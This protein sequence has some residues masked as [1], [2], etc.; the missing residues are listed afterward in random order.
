MES[1][2]CENLVDSAGNPLARVL[3]AAEIIQQTSGL[4]GRVYENVDFESK[5][6]QRTSELPCGIFL[7]ID[8]KSIGF[9]KVFCI[10]M[11]HEWT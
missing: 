5:F 8:L 11:V 4:M 3:T 7:A 9:S 1:I 2:V 6:V 10:Q